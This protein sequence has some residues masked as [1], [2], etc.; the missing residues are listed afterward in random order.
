MPV[1]L[2]YYPNL[3]H[4]RAVHREQSKLWAHSQDR[5]H[6]T[7]QLRSNALQQKLWAW[8]KLQQLY[9]PNVVVLRRKQDGS[10]GLGGNLQKPHEIPLWLPSQV[11]AQVTYNVRL[12][13]I[14]QK[15]RLGQA[16]EA[17]STLQHN[18]QMRSHLYKFKDRFVR[19]QGANTRARNAID[20]VQARVDACAGEY[21]AAHTALLALDV[22]LGKLTDS[23]RLRTLENSDIRD[24]ADGE[25]GTSEGRKKTSWIWTMV[26]L[27]GQEGDVGFMDGM[28]LRLYLCCLYST[29]YS[30][31]HRMVQVTRTG[32]AL[33]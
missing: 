22:Q 15:L 18:L 30:P 16:F 9:M 6:T 7:V 19:G 17:L 11:K 25:A 29:S 31:S 23:S 20:L 1:L 4:R 14:K 13:E 3:F 32:S 33:Q 10:D 26:G 2:S 24:L 27:E 12:A 5:Q 8:F 28:L 21:R